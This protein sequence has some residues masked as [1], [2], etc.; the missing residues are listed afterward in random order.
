MSR[1]GKQLIK[2]PSG[3]TVEIEGHKVTVKGPKGEL[4]QSVPYGITV[5]VEDSNIMVARKDDTQQQRALHGLM[6]ALIANDVNGVSNGF[7]RNLEIIGVGYR[8]NQQGNKLVLNVGYSHAVEMEV[9]EG[10]TATVADNTKIK[11]T[12]IDKAKL[13]QFAANIRKIRP[14]EPY[15]GK[16]IK[17]AEEVI[18]RKAGKAAKA[19][20]AA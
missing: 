12:G 5:S 7:E 11:L 9:P 20:K 17:Y 18:R 6:R 8:A 14:P 3:V 10:M 15:K 13:G 2:I 4:S 19:A 16:G 1:I